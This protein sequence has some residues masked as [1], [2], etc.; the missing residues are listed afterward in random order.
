MANCKKYREM[1]SCY[2]DGELSEADRSELQKHLEECASCRSLLSLYKSITG[3]A[4]ELM[5]EPPDNFAASIMEKIR[6][7]PER[8]NTDKPKAAKPKSL[9]PVVISFV[10]AAACLALA[11]IVSPQLFGFGRSSDM[12]ANVPMA[13]AAYDTASEEIALDNNAPDSVMKA[14]ESADTGGEANDGAGTAYQT[15]LAPTVTAAP[16]PSDNEAPEYGTY[17]RGVTDE[18]LSEYYAVFVIEGLRP[19]ILMDYSMTDNQDGT[20]SIEI[21]VETANQLIKEGFK[22]DMGAP[23]AAK[24]LVKYTPAP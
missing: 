22:P 12:T 14:T 16:M 17:E 8:E 9:R 18:L 4:A 20:F 23:E 24:A 21:S 13:S 1:I 5:K 6:L 2:A 11:F 7:L 10:A 19:D 3:A 15:Q